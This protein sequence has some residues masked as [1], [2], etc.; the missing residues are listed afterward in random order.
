MGR[1]QGQLDPPLSPKGL[2]QARRLAA[3][4]GH[5][6]FDAF[7]CSDLQRTAET[8][9]CLAE[10]LGRRPVPM[11]ELREIDLGDWEGLS[12]AEVEATYPDLWE[13]WRQWP[14]WDVVPGGEGARAFEQRVRVALHQLMAQHPSGDVLV[15][16]HGGVI[17]VALAEVVGKTSDG[18][19]PFRIDNASLTVIQQRHGRVA[20]T[21]VND[22]CHLS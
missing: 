2:E 13:Q 22:T 15:V 9:E 3:R 6:H 12:R 5:M 21:R 14:T 1:I 8:A 11:T 7:Y 10:T 4:L 20:V 18:P 16:T 17:Q 19:F